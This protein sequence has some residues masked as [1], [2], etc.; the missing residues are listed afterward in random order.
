MYDVF[1]R[2]V[3]NEQTSDEWRGRFLHAEDAAMFVACLGDGAVIKGHNQK[4][5]AL[6][7]EGKESQPASESYDFVANTVGQ[8]ERAPSA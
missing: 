8:R 7:I 1:L 3:V 2:S 6:W 4:T 5:R